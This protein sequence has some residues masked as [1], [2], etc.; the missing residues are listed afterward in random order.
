MGRPLEDSKR[1]DNTH[2][3][4]CAV[5]GG[6]RHYAVCCHIVERC[7]KSQARPGEAPCAKA[8]IH[9]ECPAR[10]MRLEERKAGESLYFVP[11]EQS[12][13]YKDKPS[14]PPIDVL[15]PSYQRGWD[16]AGRMFGKS[17]YF[18]REEVPPVSEPRVTKPKAPK[19]AAPVSTGN[20]YA[21]LVNKMMSERGEAK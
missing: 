9:G 8:V 18:E 21:D 15:N 19:P 13:L 4:N 14:K 10:K 11:R 1:G 20:L 12:A 16:A 7:E 2:M 6:H 3:V 17:K 5:Y